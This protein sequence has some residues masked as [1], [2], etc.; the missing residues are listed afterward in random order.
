VIYASYRD[1]SGIVT[2]GAVRLVL[3]V[4][5]LAGVFAATAVALAFGWAL[6]GRLHPRLGARRSRKRERQESRALA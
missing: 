6:A 1:V 5:P 4:A 3:A 2:P